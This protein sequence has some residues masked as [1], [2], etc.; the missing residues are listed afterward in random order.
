M[1][2]ASHAQ[3]AKSAIFDI[4]CAENPNILEIYVPKIQNKRKYMCQ[5]SKIIVNTCSQKSKI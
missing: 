5:K 1:F 4:L 3:V 2:E